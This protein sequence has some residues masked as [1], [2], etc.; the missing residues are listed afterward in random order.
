M[1]KLFGAGKLPQASASIA[2]PKWIKVGPLREKNITQIA[3]SI[4]GENIL[5]LSSEEEL[6]WWAVDGKDEAAHTS[7]REKKRSSPKTLSTDITTAVDHS[8]AAE[9]TAH[10]AGDLHRLHCG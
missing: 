3:C 2:T 7:H 6:Y 4:D 5:C 9:C 8:S 1:T 10:C